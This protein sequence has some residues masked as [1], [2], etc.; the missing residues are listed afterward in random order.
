[1]EL[2][3]LTGK[4]S[5]QIIRL[6]VVLVTE[7]LEAFDST[8]SWHFSSEH[9]LLLNSNFCW[10]TLEG[11]QAGVLL[12]KHSCHQRA[13]TTQE[14]RF[15]SPLTLWSEPRPAL[16]PGFSQGL[17][18]LWILLNVWAYTGR[19]SCFWAALGI[20]VLWSLC[21]SDAWGEGAVVMFGLFCTWRKPAGF[22]IF[23]CV[24]GNRQMSLGLSQ[25]SVFVVFI[26]QRRKLRPR[27]VNEKSSLVFGKQFEFLNRLL[28]E[29]LTLD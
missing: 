15:K 26:L 24:G 27:E 14:P 28:C 23:S 19:P 8:S 4:P 17:S 20:S 5:V 16:L 9:S 21:M 29:T 12:V 1:M 25:L 2:T 11:G 18:V 10:K 6:K 13:E 22:S 3:A 7:L